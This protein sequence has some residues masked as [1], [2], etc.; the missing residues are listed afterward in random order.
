MQ[1]HN[2]SHHRRD[3]E[4]PLSWRN[5]S[6]S[7]PTRSN[8]GSSFQ[9][10]K[11]HNSHFDNT[12]GVYGDLPTSFTGRSYGS[13][14][15]MTRQD[16]ENLERR[17]LEYFDKK[18]Y[19][20]PPIQNWH[21]P[22][23]SNMFVAEKWKEERLQKL[24]E[25]LNSVKSKLDLYNLNDW[26]KH[27]RA[28]NKAGEI[29]RK[30]R[31]EIEPEFLTQ[32]WCKFYENA[33]SFPLVPPAVVN[34]GCLNS[35]HLC[36]APGAFITSLNHFLKHHH[37]DIKWQWQ[38]TTLNPYYEGNPLSC[39]I[40]DDRFILQTLS[41]WKFG[42]DYTGNLM[43]LK[44]MQHLVQEAEKMG[45]ILLVTADGSIDCQEDPGEQESIVSSLH[46]CE[47]VSAL[48]ILSKGGSFLLKMFTMYEEE[49]VCLMYLLCCAFTSVRVFKPA[50]SKEG[51]SEVYVVCLEYK[52]KEYFEPW[53][54]VIRQHFGPE[55]PNRA[56]FPHESIPR[57]F[58][59]QLYE[60]ASMFKNFQVNVI[61]T[62]IRVYEG[63]KMRGEELLIKKLRYLIANHFM[64]TYEMKKLS[65]SDE[66]VGKSKLTKTMTL[67]MD[68]RAEEGSFDE[69]R[70]K[71]TLQ[72]L[73][74]LKT[75]KEEL[76]NIN[77]DWPF[78]KNIKYLEFPVC[79][80]G[81]ELQIGK[82]VKT[83]QSSKFCLGRLLKIRN[84]V[85]NI[86]RRDFH[87]S[88]STQSSGQQSPPLQNGNTDRS[89]D[90]TYDLKQESELSK[91]LRQEYPKTKLTILN[92]KE[93]LWTSMEGGNEEAE[94]NAFLDI[95]DVMDEMWREQN[96]LLQGYP[97][98]TQFNVGI[99]Y[100][101]CHL[102][103]TVGFVK[104]MKQDFA[105]F[106][107]GFRKWNPRMRKFLDQVDDTIQKLLD[108]G[109]QE[110]V[111]S[112]FPINKLCERYNSPYKTEG[113]QLH[114][115]R[116][117]DEHSE[118]LEDCDNVFY[119][120]VTEVN[121]LCVKEQAY[122]IITNILQQDK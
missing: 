52:G 91:M 25:E 21:L 18:F 7:S 38:A 62:N 117:G 16:Y 85:R 116:D 69:R 39:M 84:Q 63:H 24:K 74:L 93:K 34:T 121:H 30:L 9:S 10:Y 48:H 4:K 65:E 27:T 105:V 44:N 29:Q 97:M 90:E 46:Y 2:K 49:T 71:A 15:K 11:C 22:E 60:C 112:L 5:S 115:K 108:Q 70:K 89:G 61:E 118:R 50:T 76:N 86:A 42:L 98:L 80:D 87:F 35:V 40:N 31:K 106:F 28:M 57:D 120:C 68:P 1:Q 92:Y 56:M 107:V 53:L 78:T 88:S 13:F 67:N 111:L 54:I 26:H 114:N 19:F 79:V 96:L 95:M 109:G 64:E 73:Q 100:M 81:F 55:L 104:P 3:S 32:A 8:L 99:V 14:E 36:E 33:Y 47:A 72:P 12:E 45:N 37:T 119:K 23:P 66:V 101:L 51:N 113:E 20:N 94:R 6:G 110:T 102:F 17:V 122:D 41:N 103:D 77:V 83:V 82:P 59:D 75:L 58:M 43:D